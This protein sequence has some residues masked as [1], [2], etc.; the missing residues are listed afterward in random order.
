MSAATTAAMFAAIEADR[1]FRKTLEE[2]PIPATSAEGFV[3]GLAI[4]GVLAALCWLLVVAY[5]FFF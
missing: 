3:E 2:N 5:K 1:K 4:G